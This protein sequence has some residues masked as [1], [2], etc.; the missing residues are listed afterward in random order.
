MQKCRNKVQFLEEDSYSSPVLADILKYKNA[1]Q[2][3]ANFEY[4]IKRFPSTK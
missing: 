4:K 3:M 2:Y 1:I